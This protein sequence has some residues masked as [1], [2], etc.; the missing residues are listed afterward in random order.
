MTFRVDRRV[1]LEEAAQLIQPGQTLALGGMT[2]YRRPLA[3]VRALLA[4][5]DR[6]RNLTLLNFMAGFESDLL[7][8]AGCVARTRTCYFGLEAFGLA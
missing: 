6:P 3:F 8:G 7:V 1:S 2:I 5:P 4:R